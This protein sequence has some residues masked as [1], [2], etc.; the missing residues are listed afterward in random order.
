MFISK[1]LQKS[2][3]DIKF[4]DKYV[5]IENSDWYNLNGKARELIIVRVS[6][7]VKG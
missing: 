7:E 4:V 3:F 1:Q 2:C 6:V 5:H